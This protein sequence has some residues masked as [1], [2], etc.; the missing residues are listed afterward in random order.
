MQYGIGMPTPGGQGAVTAV[1]EVRKVPSVGGAVGAW[2]CTVV[3]FSA[4]ALVGPFFV[5]LAHTG[6]VQMAVSFGKGELL[7]FALAIF[8]AALSRWIVHEGPGNV[9]LTSLGAAG[10]AVSAIAI[11]AVW[12]DEY[13]VATQQSKGLLFSLSRVATYSWV[14]VI[15]AL[16]LGLVAEI[17]YA[18]SLKPSA[19]KVGP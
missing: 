1:A 14:L 17:M 16:I 18:L 6:K 13:E 15:A 11:S 2:L 12:L 5:P 3:L 8:A 19:V 9:A 7:A 4:L 10:T